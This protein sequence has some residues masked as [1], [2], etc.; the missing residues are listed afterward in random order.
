MHGLKRTI[1]RCPSWISCWIGLQERGGIV[2]LMG[3][4]VTT[5]SLLHQKIKRKPL[6]LVLMEPLHSRECHLGYVM[7]RPRFR[8]IMSIFS[9]MVGDTIEVFMN[10]F[11]VVGDSFE[12][13]LSHLSE[14]LKRCKDCNKY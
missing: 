14:V 12:R 11:S 5:K 8:C 2:F 6:L 9:Y 13:C 10:D 4:R 3:I 7:H 1:F